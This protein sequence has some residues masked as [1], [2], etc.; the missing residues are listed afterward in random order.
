MSGAVGRMPAATRASTCRTW[1]TQIISIRSRPRWRPGCWP[2]ARM[3]AS[4]CLPRRACRRRWK[5]KRS[6][7]RT[8]CIAPWMRTAT[9]TP[10]CSTSGARRAWSAWS[11][12]M[13]ARPEPSPPCIARHSARAAAWRSPHWRVP[14]CW[15][16]RPDV[17]VNSTGRV[18][19]P[20]RSA[21]MITCASSIRST[22]PTARKTSLMTTPR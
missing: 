17:M 13:K 19:S 7:A 1:A 16:S 6:G 3:H 4:R 18:I 22:A 5:T 2:M 21:P 8:I 20:M 9:S 14:R 15:P 11:P 12:V 10:R